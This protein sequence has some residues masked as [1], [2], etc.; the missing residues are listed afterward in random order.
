MGTP[1]GGPR[2]NQPRCRYTGRPVHLG[3]ARHFLRRKHAEVSE[4]PSL[5]CFDLGGVLVELA[6]GWDDACRLA[7]VPFQGDPADSVRAELDRLHATGRIT[8]D[9]WAQGVVRGGAPYSCA[10]LLRMHHAWIRKEYDGI[11]PVIDGLEQRGILTACLSNTTEGHWRRMVHRAD[12]TVLPGPAEFPSVA[13]LRWRFASHRLGLLKPD[14]AIYEAFEAHTSRRGAEIL[15]FD[16]L[17]PNVA[18]ATKRGWNAV[19]IDPTRPTAPQIVS[20]LLTYGL[21]LTPPVQHASD[22]HAD[23]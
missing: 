15:F 5:V 16:D 17:V 12:E 18:A 20:H 13:R 2:I 21:L 10:Q 7:G 22:G 8:D 1:P 23:A 11:G 4:N 3:L 6:K 19:R 14:P 9:E